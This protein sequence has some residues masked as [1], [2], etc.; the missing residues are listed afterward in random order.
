MLRV[1]AKMMKGSH[2]LRDYVAVNEEVRW[3][4]SQRLED[5]MDQICHEL[6][7]AKPIWLD[8]NYEELNRFGKTAFRQDHFIEPIAFQMLEIEI[9]EMDDGEEEE[10]A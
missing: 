4:P 8:Q 5:C 1:W 6:D 10:K 9:I 3:S 2:M 7:L